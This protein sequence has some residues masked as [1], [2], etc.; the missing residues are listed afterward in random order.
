MSRVI[1][2]FRY[3]FISPEIVW[4]GVIV[5]GFIYFNEYLLLLGKQFKSNSDMWKTLYILPF[6]FLIA[7]FK[8]TGKIR[9]PLDKEGNKILYEWPLYQ[10]LTDR[11]VFSLILGVFCCSGVILLWVF[12]YKLSEEVLGGLYLIFMGIP[13][14]SAFILILSEQKLKE[15]LTKFT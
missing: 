1:D 9:A 15:L 6:G 13:G 8:A 4:A 14:I 2:F 3:V 5:I 7:S 10:K 11:A 12:S